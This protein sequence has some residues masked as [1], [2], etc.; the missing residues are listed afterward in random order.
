MLIRLGRWALFP[1]LLLVALSPATRAD[2]ADI[3]AFFGRY[4]GRGIELEQGTVAQRAMT[5]E[6]GPTD[7]GFNVTWSTTTFGNADLRDTKSYSVNFTDSRRENIF[8]SQ[9]RM[10]KF[11]GRVPLDPLKGD[12]LIWARLIDATLTVYAMRI[13][14]EGSY[15]LQVYNRT[16]VD[17]GLRLAYTRFLEGQAVRTVDGFLKQVGP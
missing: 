10:N 9:M 14:A 11:G 2:L 6:I 12:P 1:I 5:V 13:T 17:G 16:L 7:D 4:E 15:D 3:N 8:A